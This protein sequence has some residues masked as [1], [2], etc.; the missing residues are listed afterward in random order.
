MK[1]QGSLI[2][3]MMSNNNTKPEVG[4]GAT[5]LLYSDRHAYEVV[6]VINDKKAIIQRYDVRTNPY[7]EQNYTYD[8]LLPYKDTIVFRYGSW[9]KEFDT[10]V[11]TDEFYKILSNEDLSREERAKINKECYDDNA[12]LQL[13][14][15][16]TKKVKGREK[17]RIIF[18]RKDEYY[19]PSF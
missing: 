1:L 9:W 13:V 17:I 18:G 5:I 19:D 8:T 3:C 11:Y 2:N 4:K 7:G 12:E 6:E 14:E 15:G 10:I 16:K